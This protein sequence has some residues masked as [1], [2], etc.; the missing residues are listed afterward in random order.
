M[1]TASNASACVGCFDRAFLLAG[2]CVRCVN[3][4]IG[5]VIAISYAMT[6][7]VSC[8]TCACVFLFL[9]CV[10][11]LCLLRT[12]Y[13]ACVF[14]LMQELACVWMETGLKTMIKI[15]TKFFGLEDEWVSIEFNVPPDE[16]LQAIECTGTDNQTTRLFVCAKF[17]A[18]T[19]TKTNLWQ[20]NWS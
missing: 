3:N 14:F 13:F 9:A 6:G 17:F 1:K 18:H 16:S 10:I 12:F 15:K 5:S 11:F 4:R 19:K 7:C 8:V 2:A 20:T